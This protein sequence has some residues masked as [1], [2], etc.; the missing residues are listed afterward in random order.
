MD[1]RDYRGRVIGVKMGKERGTEEE[2]EEV[3][4][5]NSGWDVRGRSLVD[6]FA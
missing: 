3:I 6:F 5:R 4:G 1:G 2:M